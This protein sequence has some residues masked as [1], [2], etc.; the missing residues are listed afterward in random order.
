MLSL[1][2]VE[3]EGE[4]EE[5]EELRKRENNVLLIMETNSNRITLHFQNL[6]AS[7]SPPST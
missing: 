1:E 2:F 3:N 6:I 4:E 5:E 7:A